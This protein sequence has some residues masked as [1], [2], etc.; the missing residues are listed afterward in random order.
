MT[1]DPNGEIKGLRHNDPKVIAALYEQYAESVLLHVERHGGNRSDAQD[2]FQETLMVLLRKAQAGGIELTAPFGAYF[3]GVAKRIWLKKSK[4][5]QISVVTNEAD[6]AFIDDGADW[7]AALLQQERYRV[8]QSAF[9]RLGETCQQ[10]LTLFFQKASFKAIADKLGLGNEH[11]VR[12]RKYRCQNKL[13]ELI[14][15]DPRFYELQDTIKQ[16]KN[17]K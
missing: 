13:E 17:G 1:L 14:K 8:Y 5:K 2:V 6:S 7:D 10:I 3:M 11:S 9:E 16:P 12:T 15:A 4:K